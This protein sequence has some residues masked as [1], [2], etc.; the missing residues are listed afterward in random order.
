MTCPTCRTK[1][2]WHG[3]AAAPVLLADLSADRSRPCGSTSA[4]GSRRACRTRRRGRRCFVRRPARSS[5]PRAAGSP[6]PTRRRAWCAAGA[7][8]ACGASLGRCAALFRRRSFVDIVTVACIVLYVVSLVFDPRGRAAAARPLQHLLAERRGASFALGRD[9]CRAL[10]ARAA[11]G[12]CSPRSICTAALLHILFNVLWIRQLGPAVEELYGPSRLVVIFTVAGVAG[13]RGLQPARPPFHDRRVGLDLR[14]A[15]RDGGL[16]SEAR[17]HVRRDGPA[18]VRT[19]GAAAVRAGLPDAGG[20]Q[21]RPRRRLRRRL[22]CRAS[23]SRSP[24]AAPRPPSINCWP[25]ACIGLTLLCFALAI[26]S[27]FA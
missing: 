3:N 14:P 13:L 7:T 21:H 24:S 20:E 15:G 23:C 8:R 26:W 12:R 1:T 25:T 19:V 9:R 18:A 4:T 16:R 27:A 17:R 11:G 5:V 22:R 2:T 10:A 6:T